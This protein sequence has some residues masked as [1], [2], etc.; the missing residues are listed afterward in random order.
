MHSGRGGAG[1]WYSPR[2]EGSTPTSTLPSS[3]TV[4]STTPNAGPSVA[5]LIND[6][7]D[8]EEKR[9][10]GRTGGGR[11]GAGNIEFGRLMAERSEKD[12][13]RGT[14]LREWRD[15]DD[16]DDDREQEESRLRERVERD[17]EM[18]LPVP[19]KAFL[20]PGR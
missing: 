12:R 9:S 14:E 4:S 2:E 3:S 10:H 16:D 1:N 11:G 15:G 6:S 5:A 19:Q 18:G 17:V 7:N 13:E 8:T 20:G